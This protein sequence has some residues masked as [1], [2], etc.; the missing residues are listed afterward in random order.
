MVPNMQLVKE[1]CEE[2]GLDFRI[3]DKLGNLAE[4]KCGGKPYFFTYTTTPFNREDVQHICNDKFLTYEL[5]STEHL[6][7]ETR[8]YLRPDLDPTWHDTIEF[9]SIADIVT[10]IQKNFSFPFVV[11]MNAGSLGRN[12]FK[13][14]N[15]NQVE[16]AVAKIFKEDWALLIQKLI[17]KQ[18]EFRV[19]VVNNSVE[20]AYTKG[21]ADFLAKGDK[22]FK[23]IKDFLA[24]LHK[25]INLGWAGLDVICDN[26]GK[27]WLIE[28]NTKPSLI[29]AI[30]AG[31]A[32]LLKPLYKKAFEEILK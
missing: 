18:K 31:K 13:C 22:T 14:E 30:K 27:F 20:L 4:V 10:D 26:K 15:E 19:L 11:K 9:S 7:P 23:E 29:S 6:M 12:I 28:I 1:F 21:G 16:K 2:E 25:H 3:V 5:L 32:D 8:R 24:P 17:Q